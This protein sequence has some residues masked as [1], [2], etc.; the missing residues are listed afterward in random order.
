MQKN[1]IEVNSKKVDLSK[2]DTKLAQPTKTSI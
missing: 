2:T 1:N